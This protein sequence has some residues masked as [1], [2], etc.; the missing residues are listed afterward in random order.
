M[1]TSVGI[2]FGILYWTMNALTLI[3]I[4]LGYSLSANVT[5]NLVLQII[6]AIY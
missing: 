3:L 5:Q 1:P 2:I 6:G 4:V